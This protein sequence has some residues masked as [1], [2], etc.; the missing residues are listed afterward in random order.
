MTHAA[1]EGHRG[2][3]AGSSWGCNLVEDWA[4]GGVEGGTDPR[5]KALFSQFLTNQTVLHQSVQRS[6]G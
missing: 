2:I 1:L 3:G 4:W 5:H 6:A